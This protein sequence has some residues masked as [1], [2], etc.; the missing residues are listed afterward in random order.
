M[1]KNNS[2]EIIYN[3]AIFHESYKPTADANE[4]FSFEFRKTF[5]NSYS[6]SKVRINRSFPE[7]SIL[8]V[9]SYFKNCETHQSL[10]LTSIFCAVITQSP[11]GTSQFHLYAI[12]VTDIKKVRKLSCLHKNEAGVHFSWFFSLIMWVLYNQ[13]RHMICFILRF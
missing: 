12:Y 2:Q 7:P 5:G 1:T 8:P 10:R 4:C 13:K 9:I 11:R 6:Y 3:G